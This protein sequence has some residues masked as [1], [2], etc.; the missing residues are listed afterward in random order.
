LI[1]NNIIQ[2]GQKHVNFSALVKDKAQNSYSCHIMQQD[3]C[4]I[5]LR[6]FPETTTTIA[7][8]LRLSGFCAGLSGTRKV[9]PK[10]ISIYW[11]KREWQRYQLGHMQIC[12][13]PQ[14][15][16]HASTPPHI[17]YRPDAFPATQPT[18]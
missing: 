9:K 1:N 13:L 2:I 15:D 14:T 8:I 4:S 7:T 6:P 10:I 16:N 5:V 3:N 18:A 11:S 12:T 17:F